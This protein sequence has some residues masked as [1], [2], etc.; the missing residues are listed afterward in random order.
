MHGA[1][2][3]VG[4]LRGAWSEK[5]EPSEQESDMSEQSEGNDSFSF[6]LG[7]HKVVVEGVICKT[8]FPVCGGEYFFK[9]I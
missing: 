5:K 2:A 3:T 7:V 4:F 9:T 6:R 1:R 8:M